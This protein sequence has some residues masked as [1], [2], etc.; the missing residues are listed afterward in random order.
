VRSC[1][2]SGQG[3]VTSPYLGYIPIQPATAR[4]YAKDVAW[5]LVCTR[6]RP[7][8]WSVCDDVATTGQSVGSWLPVCCYST[9]TPKCISCA[10]A[11]ST[12]VTA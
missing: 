7:V 5:W 9:G 4:C 2:C 10:V 1:E 12:A 8:L 6:T 3:R 11:V